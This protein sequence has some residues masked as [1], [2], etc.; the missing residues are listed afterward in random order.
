MSATYAPDRILL[1]KAE[2]L[3]E[4]LPYIQRY[5]GKIFVVKYGG[6]AMGNPD[7]AQDFAEDIVL[8]K[9][10]GIHPVVVHGGGP[11]IGKMLKALGVESQFIDGLRVTDNE[12]AKIAEM[13]LSGAIN[14]DIVSW[15]GRAGGRAVG[16]SGKDA[17]LVE[18]EKV[19]KIRKNSTDGQDENIDLGFV[20]RPV[21]VDRRL[22]DTLTQS[23]MIPVVAPIGV[24]ADGETYNINAD[25]MAGALAAGLEAARLFLLT[26]VA[27]V[28]DADKKLL[29]TLTPSQIDSLTK[30]DVISGGMIP[31]LETCIE[32]VKSGV[33]AAVILDGRVPHSILIELFTEQG[34]GTLVKLD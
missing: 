18:V 14:K 9:A 1:E 13:V 2:T 29:R 31:K 5:A 8:L 19:K 11:Q 23:G 27:G 17:K 20:G 21:S 12:T 7:A 26:D 28:L 16:I 10:I 4:A 32:S 34:A 15:I 30:A 33:D 6:H 24:G 3:S 25:T 22:I